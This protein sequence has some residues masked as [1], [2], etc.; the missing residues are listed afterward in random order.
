MQEN[1]SIQ[2]FKNKKRFKKYA[3]TY[4]LI[5]IIFL[6]FAGGFFSGAWQA[7]NV[8]PSELVYSVINKSEVSENSGE[9]D[10]DLFWEVWDRVKDKHLEQPVDEK[11]LFYGAIAGVVAS[12]EDPY[13]V[14]MDPELTDYFQESVN[15]NFEG[16][17]AEIGIR[18][19]QLVVVAPLNGTPAS[20]AGLMAGDRILAIDGSDTFEMTLDYAVSIIRGDKGTDVVLTVL[21]EEETETREV[22]ITRDVIVIK[23][24]DWEMIDGNIALVELSHFNEDTGTR[25]SSIANDILLEQPKGIILDLRNNP[26]GYLSASI[27][28]ASLFI[29]KGKVVVIEAYSSGRKENYKA[30]GQNKFE[31]I[32]LVVLINRGSASASEI[33]AG[34]LSDYKLAQLVGETT[35][36]K[37]SIQDYEE[38]DDGSSLKITVAN[39]LTPNGELIDGVGIDPDHEIE[40]TIEDY[41]AD[42]DPQL[43]KAIEIINN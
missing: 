10:F 4:F 35:F 12:L 32:K 40:L 20:N 37:G 27:E 8:N 30:L 34:A 38:F 11:S 5:L 9:L 43:D 3:W 17:G 33:L 22:I 29:E 28:V 1:L 23:S 25:F 2:E 39:W 15:G 42:Q 41:N 36:G 14:Y 24:I 13:S 21:R 26:G 18:N 7:S 31:G 19:E 6:V 16:I